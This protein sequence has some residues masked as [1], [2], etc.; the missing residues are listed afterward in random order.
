VELLVLVGTALVVTEG[1]A[2]PSLRKKRKTLRK[3]QQQLIMRPVE[4]EHTAQGAQKEKES[5]QISASP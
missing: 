2:I 1:G 3:T 5:T 4:L